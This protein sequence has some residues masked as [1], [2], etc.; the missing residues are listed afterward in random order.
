MSDN[1]FGRQLVV[2]ELRRQL[3]LFHRGWDALD[4]KASTLFTASGILITIA[5]LVGALAQRQ[6]SCIGLVCL[7]VAFVFYFVLY[8]VLFV[9]AGPRSYRGTMTVDWTEQYQGYFQ[10]SEAEAL[11]QLVAEYNETICLLGKANHRKSS[12]LTVAGALFLVIVA[13]LLA[14]FS[15][16]FL[17]L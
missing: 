5:G 14:S 12:A 13:L 2:D 16:S 8:L 15:A 7:W 3:D 11:E 17:P 4:A 1:L 10:K 6:A 9:A